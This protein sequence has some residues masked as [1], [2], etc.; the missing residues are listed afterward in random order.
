MERF[1]E[2][3][4]D[5]RSILVFSA[6]LSLGLFC[7]GCDGSD[8]LTADMPLH[9]EDHLDVA[10]IMGSEVPTDLPQP[11][12]W[13]FDEPQPEWRPSKA[14]PEGMQTV[15]PVQL[16]DA[17]RLPLTAEM[18]NP[19]GYRFAAIYVDLPDWTLEDWGYVEI[20]ARALGVFS[21]LGLRFNYTE[22]NP[23]G[24]NLPFFTRGD[25]SPV[26]SDGTVETYRLTLD[27]GE[28]RDRPERVGLD[29]LWTQL[30]VWVTCPDYQ[31]LATLD[32]L[33]IRVVPRGHEY[34]QDR[35]SVHKP[36]L[37]G[38]GREAIVTHTPSRLEW[39]IRVPEEGRLDLA[40]APLDRGNETTF[41]ASVSASGDETVVL[42]EA[43][44]GASAWHL[45]SADLGE[46]AGRT[47][48]LALEAQAEREGN[49][50]FWGAPTLSG[51][52]PPDKPNVILYVIDGAGADWMS[53]YGYNRL[54][55][56]FLERLAREGVVFEHAYS[57]ATS[58]P[59][60]N[61]SFMT[62]LLF[63]AIM[64]YRTYFERIPDGVTTMVEHFAREGWLTGIFTSNP[65]ASTIRG[66]QRNADRV[67]FAP[68]ENATSSQNLHRAF[69]EWR[70]GW[71]GQ[72]FWAHFQT[73][74]V[75]GPFDQV[76]PFAGLFLT[77]E[78]R[79]QYFEWNEVVTWWDSA[80]Y[81]EAG[82]TVA[83][84]ALAQQS[85]YDEGM[86]HQDYQLERLVTR[87]KAEGRYGN[88]ILV[89]SSD[90]GYP[91]GGHRIMPGMSPG[92]PYIHPF[93]TRIP[94][95]VLWPG[96][97]PGGRR[98]RTPV[99][100]LD[101]LPT[102]LDLAGLPEPK[103]AQ[104]QS[105]APLLLGQITEEERG[106]HPVFVDVLVENQVSG[107]L[108]GG[109]EVIH[110]R[111]GASLCVDPGGLTITERR[112]SVGDGLPSCVGLMRAERLL[113]FDLWEDPLLQRPI[114]EQ[115]PDLVEK[116]TALLEA[117]MEANAA[118]RELV[119]A[120]G[121]RTALTPE[122]LE[123]LRTLGYIR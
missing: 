119:G 1:S 83:E 89:I 97:I 25:Y 94:L 93:A 47:V 103:L 71:P 48:K 76:P 17:L 55:T 29:G 106:S 52:P 121:E 3:P 69:W 77:P 70:D 100:M 68:I 22:E 54:T 62:S 88:T 120:G 42:Q 63:S 7:S 59:L 49:I 65:H 122:Q 81:A 110:G 111:W 12:E 10:T 123:M 36:I 80:S 102:L 108:M 45:G 87:L 112:Y 32:I 16:D 14:L 2:R 92:A 82:T 20:R 98:I 105:L 51:Q 84:F 24:P 117:Q 79:E 5:R 96:H 104:G 40:Y 4:L 113:L 34:H 46:Y 73:T 53:L 26:V 99:S 23:I 101:V 64:P 85:L 109:I 33:S 61:P 9:L 115:R 38:V 18:A 95:M 75:H 118:M 66:L 91:A 78:K 107:E 57:T 35:V 86:A 11:V 50:V 31:E 39:Q 27:W 114:N 43:V 90:H 30:A 8:T 44:S 28:V 74:D 72:P 37:D 21:Y 13:R 19:D 15:Q 67:G 58:T 41:R 60:S 6:L 56:P 116:Y